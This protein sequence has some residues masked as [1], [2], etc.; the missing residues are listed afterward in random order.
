MS[1]Y[2]FDDLLRD[3]PIGTFQNFVIGVAAAMLVARSERGDDLFVSMASNALTHAI[4]HDALQCI[5]DAA[6]RQVSHA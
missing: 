4:D 3:Y 6:S 2:S 5:R 1:D